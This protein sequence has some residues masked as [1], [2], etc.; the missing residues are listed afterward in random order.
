MITIYW[1]LLTMVPSVGDYEK[2]KENASLFGSWEIDLHLSI[3]I[4]A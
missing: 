2:I 4:S 3:V 1:H